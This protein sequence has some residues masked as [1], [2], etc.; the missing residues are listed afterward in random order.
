MGEHGASGINGKS[1]DY[2]IHLDYCPIEENFTRGAQTEPCPVEP[3]GNPFP[4]PDATYLNKSA[5]WFA[6]C[7]PHYQLELKS[8]YD[9]ARSDAERAE[10]ASKNAQ[11]ALAMNDQASFECWKGLALAD[12]AKLPHGELLAVPL[13]QADLLTFEGKYLEAS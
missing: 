7:H 5:Q 3:V 13:L 4:P 2:S 6:A 11:V 8:N 1:P 10:V 9:G 12:A